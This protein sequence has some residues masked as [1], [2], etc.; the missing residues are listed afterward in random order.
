PPAHHAR[1]GL[2][3]DLFL[4]LFIP[5]LRRDHLHFHP[6]RL[7]PSRWLVAKAARFVA[8]HH[9]LRPGLFLFQPLIEPRRFKP[10][11]WLHHRVI[12]LSHHPKTLQVH[13][14]R[15]L[16]QLNFVLYRRIVLFHCC[17]GWRSFASSTTHDIY[18]PLRL[19]RS[20]SLP[21]LRPHLKA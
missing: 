4:A 11:C 17:R 10:L 21:S 1:I 7:H 14:D 9:P 19:R 15:D 6:H 16:A 5:V 12:L 2:V 20:V 13:V 8:H 18:Y 3:I